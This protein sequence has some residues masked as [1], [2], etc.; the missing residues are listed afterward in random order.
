MSALERVALVTGSGSGLGR[1]TAM[2]LACS[3]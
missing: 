1:V 3:G 2:A